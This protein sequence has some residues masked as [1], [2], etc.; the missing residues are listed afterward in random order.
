MSETEQI[1]SVEIDGHW[2]PPE[3]AGG[4]SAAGGLLVDEH[5]EIDVGV[6]FIGGL[7]AAIMF[8]RRGR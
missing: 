8:K 3:G 4:G 5:P 6:A 1:E 7:I 2:Q